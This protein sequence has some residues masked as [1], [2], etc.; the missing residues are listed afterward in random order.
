MKRTMES[1]KSI[2]HNS[3]MARNWTLYEWVNRTQVLLKMEV[4]ISERAI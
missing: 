1:M 3:V 2:L 4:A